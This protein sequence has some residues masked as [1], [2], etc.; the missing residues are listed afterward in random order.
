MTLYLVRHA[1]ALAKSSWSGLDSDRPLDAKGRRQ[2]VGLTDWFATRAVDAVVTSP[3]V[4]CVATVLSVA[5]HHDVD[6]VTTRALLVGADKEARKLVRRLGKQATRRGQAVIV[7]THGE[8]LPSLLDA[9]G[10]DGDRSV[11]HAKGSVWT[12]EERD[13]GPKFHY[14][15]PHPGED[16]VL[17]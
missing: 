6:L 14:D 9:L 16:P 2:V 15:L 5:N 11:Q 7:C 1:L 3:A 13:G 4:R 17:T 10:Y 8:V 12:V